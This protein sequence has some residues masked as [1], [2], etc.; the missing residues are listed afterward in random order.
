[1]LLKKELE[2]SLICGIHLRWYNIYNNKEK[3]GHWDCKDLTCNLNALFGYTRFLIFNYLGLTVS[4][5]IS[6]SSVTSRTVAM[7]MML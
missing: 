7:A 6:P 2:L 5:L 1:M 3:T 4:L